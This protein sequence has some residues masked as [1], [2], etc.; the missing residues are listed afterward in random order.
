MQEDLRRVVLPRATERLTGF[1]ARLCRTGGEQG[2]RG[3]VDSD[4][5][6]ITGSRSVPAT[7]TSTA[8]AAPPGD[9]ATSP[10]VLVSPPLRKDPGAGTATPRPSPRPPPPP[11]RKPAAV[12]IP[13]AELPKVAIEH[14]VV[15]PADAAALEAP[16]ARES[17]T[18]DRIRKPGRPVARPRLSGRALWGAFGF[19]ALGS[20]LF[21]A[22]LVTRAVVDHS[23]AP[24]LPRTPLASPRP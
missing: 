6:K 23:P 11:P 9:S 4:S 15:A 10:T 12:E 14:T 24:R 18:T 22:A 5:W 19:G 21:L 17:E 16:P 7:P 20:G 3:L 1:L 2:L 8:A 13:M